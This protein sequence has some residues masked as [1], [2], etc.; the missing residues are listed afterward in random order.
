MALEGVLTYVQRALIRLLEEILGYLP[1]VFGALVV[2]YLGRHFAKLSVKVYTPVVAK[3]FKRP[4]IIRL[5]L[6]GLR[7]TIFLVS[8]IIALGLLGIN[9]TLY[10][11]P[12]LAGAGIAGIIV[13]VTVAPI[14]SSYLAGV[15]IIIDRPY[16]IG[17]RI[18]VLQ[19]TPPLV[20][21]VAEIGLRTTKIKTIEGNV[22]VVPN[23]NIMN[24]DIINYSSEDPR[25]RRELPFEIAYESDLKK[26]LKIMEK[27]A[28]N[29][30]GVVKRGTIELGDLEYN[31]APSA[32][33]NGFGDNGI[34]LTL[35]LWLNDPYRP[36]VTISQ[37]YKTVFDEFKKEG[38]EIPYPHQHLVVGDKLLEDVKSK[39]HN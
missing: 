31:L 23:V 12:L 29:T 34:D 33:V 11:T 37:I 18:E 32:L 38:I 24:K 1:K 15:F 2:L 22:V 16:E 9:I 8:L 4:A 27:V 13:G 7:Y 3:T 30:E 25:N 19:T 10:L 20:G 35:R 21:Y 26:A 28:K 39:F 36:K 6:R 5:V 17:E 14:V